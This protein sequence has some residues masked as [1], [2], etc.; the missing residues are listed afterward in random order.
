MKKEPLY[1]FDCGCSIPISETEVKTPTKLKK[2]TTKRLCK[3][4]GGNLLYKIATCNKCGRKMKM[5]N[6]CHQKKCECGNLIKVFA[7]DNAYKAIGIHPFKVKE[8][9]F[10]GDEANVNYGNG[11]CTKC[12]HEYEASKIDIALFD[13]FARKVAEVV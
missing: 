8:C 3:N 6:R 9:N 12:H 1:I 5:S 11:L 2:R 10:C 7:G 13:Q 4:H